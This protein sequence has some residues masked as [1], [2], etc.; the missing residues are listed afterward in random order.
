MR[1]LQDR[2]R[3]SIRLLPSLMGMFAVVYFGYHA[4]QGHNGILA[5]LSLEQQV[6]RTQAE[7]AKATALQERLRHHVTLLTPNSIDRDMLE[8]QARLMLNLAHPDDLVIPRSDGA[9]TN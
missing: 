1:S 3:S 2:I 7:L 4:I 6:E 5:V 8:E 9:W